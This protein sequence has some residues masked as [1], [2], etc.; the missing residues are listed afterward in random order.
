MVEITLGNSKSWMYKYTKQRILINEQNGAFPWMCFTSF[1]IN[2]INCRKQ[3][4]KDTGKL[5]CP[6]LSK[7]TT[8]SIENQSCLATLQRFIHLTSEHTQSSQTTIS[9]L[10][11]GHV[12]K[13]EQ[14][15]KPSKDKRLKS[16]FS[17][18]PEYWRQQLIEQR[19]QNE[20]VSTGSLIACLH[21][22]MWRNTRPCSCSVTILNNLCQDLT[23]SF[24]SIITKTYKIVSNHTKI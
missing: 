19:I 4:G 1:Q 20:Y 6:P 14:V 10:Q 12:L 16:V 18:N 15:F 9:M 13:I 23:C 21:S 11:G 7:M 2:E 24:F 22:N 3:T 8:K 17:K 5:W